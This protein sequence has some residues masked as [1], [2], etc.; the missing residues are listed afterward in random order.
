MINKRLLIGVLVILLINACGGEQSVQVEPLKNSEKQVVRE[1]HPNG[2]LKS[3]AVVKDDTLDGEV[4]IYYENGSIANVSNYKND[5]QVG[6]NLI[7]Y[8]NGIL[9]IKE[10]YNTSGKLDGKVTEYFENGELRLEGQY[11]NGLKTGVWKEY[12]QNGILFEENKFSLD[13]LNGLQKLFHPNGS[14]AVKGIM[15]MGKE[16]K[17]WLFLGADGDTL[18]IETYQAGELIHV[19]QYKESQKANYTNER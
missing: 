19:K 10:H 14:L 17:D 7:Y 6:E 9:K 5:V 8:E 2:T 13:D 4:K 18:K 16:E 11:E 1:F 3:E 15:N 12:Y